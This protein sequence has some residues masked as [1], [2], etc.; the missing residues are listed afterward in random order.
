MINYPYIFSICVHV[1]VACNDCI[2]EYCG[3][4]QQGKRIY[5]RNTRR[6]NTND[7]LTC[8]QHCLQE[9]TFLCRHA[10]FAPPRGCHLCNQGS[11]QVPHQNFAAMSA[12]NRCIFD[13]AGK[14]RQFTGMLT[15]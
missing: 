6:L 3:I 9:T 12:I 15:K 4:V 11:Y 13:N 8:F 5:D 1:P 2:L 7:L 14:V 10:E